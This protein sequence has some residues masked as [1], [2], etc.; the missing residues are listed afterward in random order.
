MEDIVKGPC[1]ERLRTCHLNIFKQEIN[2][3]WF[4]KILETYCGNVL[5]LELTTPQDPF[6]PWNIDL[7]FALTV[8]KGLNS[9]KILIMC[10]GSRSELAEKYGLVRGLY[11]D[12]T[13]KVT[14][15]PYLM[16][17]KL[18]IENRFDHRDCYKQKL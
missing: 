17:K 8:T 3:E 15:F 9:L 4:P 11:C 16:L 2:E 10:L 6:A 7:G 14:W 12:R 5:Q 13:D 1:G 18:R